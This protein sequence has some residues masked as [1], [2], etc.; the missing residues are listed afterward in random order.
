MTVNT[1]QADVL[2]DDDVNVES[3]LYS[4]LQN[5]DRCDYCSARAYVRVWISDST[6]PFC[7]HDFKENQDKLEAVADHVQDE[8]HSILDS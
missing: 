4:P 6:L 3:V 2:F 8:T 5:S 7:G 1:A